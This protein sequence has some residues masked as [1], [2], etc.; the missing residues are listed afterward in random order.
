MLLLLAVHVLAYSPVPNLP[1]PSAEPR[2]VA[3]LDLSGDPLPPRAIARLGTLR[4]QHANGVSAAA[5][6]PDGKTL[7]ACGFDGVVVVWE[8][9]SGR[10]L[11][12]LPGWGAGRMR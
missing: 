8:V 2:N 1:T 7:A 12:R 6:S 9:S 3:A 11:R 10:E 5:W 4:F